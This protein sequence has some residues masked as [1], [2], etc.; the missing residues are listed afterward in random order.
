MRFLILIILLL[1]FGCSGLAS[2]VTG[3][4]GNIA[5]DTINRKMED[6]VSS[7]CKKSDD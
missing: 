5:S 2:F 6:A 3:F 4:T 7:D 1:Q